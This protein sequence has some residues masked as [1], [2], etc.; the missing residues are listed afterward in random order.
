MV[1]IAKLPF[2]FDGRPD[3]LFRHR[4]RLPLLEFDVCQRVI[5]LSVY[6]V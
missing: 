6:S 3:V 4:Y 2:E 1:K 5:M